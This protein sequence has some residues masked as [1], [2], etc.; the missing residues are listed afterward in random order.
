MIFREYNMGTESGNN[1]ESETVIEVSELMVCPHYLE[2]K[3]ALAFN[4]V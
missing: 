4:F 2:A 1:F 3:Q